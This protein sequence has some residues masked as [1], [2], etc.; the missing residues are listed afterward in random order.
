MKTTNAVRLLGHALSC[1]FGVPMLQH[2]GPLIVAANHDYHEF[3]NMK[4]SKIHQ[5][6][7][8]LHANRP[9]MSSSSILANTSDFNSM[10]NSNKRNGGLH[11]HILPGSTNSSHCSGKGHPHGWCW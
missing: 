2:S 6:S 10:Y 11:T 8:M 3:V 5:A 9:K 1:M 4:L 7:W